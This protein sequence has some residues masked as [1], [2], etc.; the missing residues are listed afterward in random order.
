[1]TDNESTD[2]GWPAEYHDPRDRP[3]PDTL[4]ITVEPFEQAR[5]E[6]LA[7]ARTA[8]DGES[9]PA[10]VSFA[11]IDDLRKVLTER[12]IEL[13]RLL[14]AIDGAAESISALAEALDRDYRP[15]HDDVGVLDQYGLIFVVDEGQ[16]KRPYVPYRRVHLNIELAGDVEDTTHAL[17]SG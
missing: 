10:V 11:S 9:T 6:T 16:T 7:A 4:R 1:M 13:L 14:I 8:E 3:H 5:E 12:R 15:V 2:D 17:A